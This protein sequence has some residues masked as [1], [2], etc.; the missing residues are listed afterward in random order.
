MESVYFSSHVTHYWCLKHSTQ[1]YNFTCFMRGNWF[2]AVKKEQWEGIWGK[3]SNGMCKP[4]NEEIAEA[5]RS[6][7]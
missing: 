6:V 7:C 3:L 5:K 2:V 1:N 4:K